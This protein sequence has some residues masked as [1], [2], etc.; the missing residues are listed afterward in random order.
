MTE[1]VERVREEARRRE[2]VGVLVR[3]QENCAR[4]GFSNL[5]LFSVGS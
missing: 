1:R 4:R 3:D 5:P 2:S